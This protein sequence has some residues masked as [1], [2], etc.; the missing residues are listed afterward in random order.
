MRQSKAG[1]ATARYANLVQDVTRAWSRHPYGAL[2]AKLRR[3]HWPPQAALQQGPPDGRARGRNCGR[4]A[5]GGSGPLA[6]PLFRR[7]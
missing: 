3:G 1:D 5:R 4:R 2:L 6:M 7:E